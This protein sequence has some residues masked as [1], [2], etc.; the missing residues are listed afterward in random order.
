MTRW[1]F[2]SRAVWKRDFISPQFFSMILLDDSAT[3]FSLRLF[4]A[5]LGLSARFSPLEQ[6]AAPEDGNSIGDSSGIS[7]GFE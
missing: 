5:T 6:S 3:D 1:E 4:P 2:F 7:R